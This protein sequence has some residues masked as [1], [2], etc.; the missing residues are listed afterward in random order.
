[1][2]TFSYSYSIDPYYSSSMEPLSNSGSGPISD[3]FQSNPALAS[4][5]IALS[6]FLIVFI[7]LLIAIAIG[8]AILAIAAQWKMYE[9]AGEPGWAC[10]VPFY[11]NYVLY[12]I[13]LGNG[14]LF[15]TILLPIVGLV[16]YIMMLIQLAK[17]FG[18]S[19]PFV[20]A[21][22]FF[23]N[24]MIY[25]YGL[26]EIEYIGNKKERNGGYI[27]KEPK[28]EKKSKRKEQHQ[29]PAM[30]DGPVPLSKRSRMYNEGKQ[31]EDIN[32]YSS[33]DYSDRQARNYSSN[34][35][36][37]ANTFE[38]D[39]YSSISSPGRSYDYEME[40]QQ[41]SRS[42]EYDMSGSR[43]RQMREA[44]NSSGS[45]VSNRSIYRNSRKDTDGMYTGDV[46][47]ITGSGSGNYEMENPFEAGTRKQRRKKEIEILEKE[48]F[49]DDSEQETQVLK[50][51]EPDISYE[52]PEIKNETEKQIEPSFERRFRRF[53]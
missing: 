43:G 40:G 30:N 6:S 21:T 14:W 28:K 22:V 1:M 15:L 7:V 4:I 53:D 37:R 16:F 27:P 20:L 39:K 26:G 12:K 32:R 34:R 5:L 3:L 36:D 38:D 9:K 25:V 31:P 51:K 44:N 41:K 10:I 2:D 11:S 17:S 24:I 33:S 49:Y 19:T 29:E 48:N 45:R 50:E 23:P 42:A 35:Y 52:K 47:G 13:T 46:S 18:R 8:A